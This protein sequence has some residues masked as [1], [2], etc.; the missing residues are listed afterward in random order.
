MKFEEV[1]SK[2]Q[3]GGG[4][5]KREKWP[6]EAQRNSN[7]IAGFDSEIY[8]CVMFINPATDNYNKF[9]NELELGKLK[10]LE[11]E[12]FAYNEI[13]S[14]PENPYDKQLNIKVWTDLAV[15]VTHKD[16]ELIFVPYCNGVMLH[17][18]KVNQNKR[19]KGVGTKVMNKL[20][21]CSEKLDIP[22]FLTPY[23]DEIIEKDTLWTRIEK[24]RNWYSKL[25]FGG[26]FGSEW[27]WSNYYEQDLII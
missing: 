27:I 25:G 3:L 11:V 14:V 6:I 9:M 24:L 19:G 12:E 10:D 15:R 18:I 21:D 2:Y 22:L 23:P 1:Q 17:S 4:T 26:I 20:Y 16:Y 8:N 13:I 7:I 5:N